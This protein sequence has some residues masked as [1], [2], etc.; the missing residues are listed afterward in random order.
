MYD[1][2]YV[3]DIIMNWR[4]Y[5]RTQTGVRRHRRQYPRNGGPTMR[6][7][8]RV[9]LITPDNLRLDGQ[10]A[11]ITRL[12]D[13]GAFCAVTAAAT[14]EF[15]AVWEEMEL[16]ASTY[17]GDCCTNCGSMRMRWAGTCKVCEDCGESGGCA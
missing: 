16:L 11:V 7:G 13:W 10:Q 1:A 17:T 12:T 3:E 2:L 4:K 8:D 6:V 5:L 9:R 15:R 14:H